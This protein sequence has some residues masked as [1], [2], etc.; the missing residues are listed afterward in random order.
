MKLRKNDKKNKNTGPSGRSD[1]SRTPQV[2]RTVL[3]FIEEE[4]YATAQAKRQYRVVG[5]FSLAAF[6][7]IASIGGL[8]KFQTG[9]ARSDLNAEL[10][11]SADARTEIGQAITQASG[12]QIRPDTDVAAHI[13]ER[14]REITA[15]LGLDVDAGTILQG[16]LTNTPEGV[17][18]TSVALTDPLVKEVLTTP[19]Q[20]STTTVPTTTV[21]TA[22]LTPTRAV[23]IK[24]SASNYNTA[25]EWQRRLQASGL[26]ATD[27]VTVK[28]DSVLS[29]RVGVTAD[30]KVNVLAFQARR[31]QILATTGQ[32]A[33]PTRDQEE[34]R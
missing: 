11:R 32:T 10:S 1:A 9:N 18:V 27:S 6:V 14:V 28:Q 16:V 3:N 23:T 25:L 26:F 33:T 17:V 22:T 21:P 30:A 24:A 19:E 2:P 31:S 12:G 4:S 8:F 29:N 7:T 5:A 20:R 34:G 15:A 13:S